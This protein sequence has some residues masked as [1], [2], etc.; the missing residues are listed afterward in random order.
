M[1]VL[2]TNRLGADNWNTSKLTAGWL[3]DSF[4]SFL[5]LLILP[6]SLLLIIVWLYLGSGLVCSVD[7]IIRDW[8]VVHP[9]YMMTGDDKHD[10][11]WL[12]HWHHFKQSKCRLQNG[13]NRDNL[14]LQTCNIVKSSLYFYGVIMFNVHKRDRGIEDMAQR[15][16][17]FKV[18]IFLFMCTAQVHSNKFQKY[19]TQ[20]I[21]MMWFQS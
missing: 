20:W 12:T 5:K 11:T 1:H 14:S 4:D 19:T 16:K 2:G 6:H 13:Q 10:K 21:I 7:Q 3:A 18:H 8:T 15:K 9:L 17:I